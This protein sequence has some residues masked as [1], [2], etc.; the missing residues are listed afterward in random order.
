MQKNNAIK[1]QELEIF[2]WLKQKGIDCF[3]YKNI[4]NIFINEII[5]LYVQDEY[6]V[7]VD[8]INIIDE[9]K[10]RHKYLEERFYKNIFNKN[11]D[12]GNFIKSKEIKL[13]NLEKMEISKI[14]SQGHINRQLKSIIIMGSLDIDYLD[15]RTNLLSRLNQKILLNLIKKIL[16]LNSNIKSFINIKRFILKKNAEK[17]VFYK[18]R[19]KFLLDRQVTNPQRVRLINR[20]QFFITDIISNPHKI[21]SNYLFIKSYYAI[22]SYV[23]FTKQEFDPLY[24][25]A[26]EIINNRDITFKNSYI[27]KFYKNPKNY[28]FGKSFNLGIKNKYYEL[29]WENSFSPWAHKKP[30]INVHGGT[31]E[32]SL[33]KMRFLKIRNTIDNIIE[34]GFIPTKNDIVKGYFLVKGNEYR[35]IV[36][37]GWHRLAVLKALHTKNHLKFNYIPVTFDLDRSK[38]NF[39]LEENIRNWPAVKEGNTSLKDAEEIFNSYFI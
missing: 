18:K 23:G 2:K 19:S 21:S 29:D 15:W 27:N 38:K 13:S 26:L 16:F 32:P 6:K 30:R 36:L 20:K 3:S 25:C 35:F 7:F 10:Y 5:Y 9:V 34:F 1:L 28:K 17:N 39:V 12:I 4:L 11:F 14:V 37:Q 24:L 33:I 22:S 31:I 8:E